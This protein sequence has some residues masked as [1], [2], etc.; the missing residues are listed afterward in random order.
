MPRLA[1]LIAP[2][3]AA[4][5]TGVAGRSKPTW[6]VDLAEKDGTRL[7]IRMTLALEADHWELYSSPGGVN[8]LINWRQRLLGRLTGKLPPKGALI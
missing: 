5:L 2:F 1:R 8:Q 6:L 4:L 3:F 7:S